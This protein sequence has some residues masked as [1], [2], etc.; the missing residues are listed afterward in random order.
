MPVFTYHYLC[1]YSPPAVWLQHCNAPDVSMQILHVCQHTVASIILTYWVSFISGVYSFHLSLS[2]SY[3]PS[4]S[5]FPPGEELGLVPS[6]ESHV[7]GEQRGRQRAKWDA[8]SAGETGEHC[9]SGGSALRPAGW[10]QR[11]GRMLLQAF[12]MLLWKRS[13]LSIV[14]FVTA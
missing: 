1:I 13:L 8:V 11:T 2:F 10:A 4:L 3:I 5:P 9:Q 7:S 6:Y 14:L 12:F